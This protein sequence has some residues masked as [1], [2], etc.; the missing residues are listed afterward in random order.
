MKRHPLAMAFLWICCCTISVCELAG[1]ICCYAS[2]GK[3]IL[4]PDGATQ[5]QAHYRQRYVGALIRLET[6]AYEPEAEVSWG[7]PGSLFPRSATLSSR[8]TDEDHV[9][10]SDESLRLVFSPDSRHLA[11]V[12][13]GDLWVVDVR[14]ARIWKLTDGDSFVSSFVWLSADVMGY[15]IAKQTA[16]DLRRRSRGGYSP[17]DRYTVTFWRCRADPAARPECL[18]AL[19]NIPTPHNLTTAPLVEEAPSYEWRGCGETVIDARTG[20]VL[21]TPAAR[22]SLPAGGP[23]R[24]PG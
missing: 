23:A 11:L 7:R 15:A 17:D 5:A 10:L 18:H 16:G 22:S 2:D 1:C 20:K 3:P 4:S 13:G 9:P 14:N 24:S 8:D 12:T 19:C 6:L 21:F